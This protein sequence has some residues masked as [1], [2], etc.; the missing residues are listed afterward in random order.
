MD[1]NSDRSGSLMWPVAFFNQLS[2][3]KNWVLSELD[4]YCPMKLLNWKIM[5]NHWIHCLFSDPFVH[6]PDI[7]CESQRPWIHSTGQKDLEV[8][9]LATK[10]AQYPPT[11]YGISHIYNYILYN[12][13][14]L[15]YMADI[16]I[17]HILSGMHI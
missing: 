12:S 6:F 10:Y 16:W 17:N 3:V 14:I 11:I 8:G 15:E 2:D 1:H 13:Y 5:R 9:I 4:G 7:F